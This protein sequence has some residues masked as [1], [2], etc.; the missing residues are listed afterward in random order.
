LPSRLTHETK[1]PL[2]VRGLRTV[3][4]H[5]AP[6]AR[7]VRINF[8]PTRFVEELLEKLEH[9]MLSGAS[10]DST[11]LRAPPRK[12]WQQVFPSTETT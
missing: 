12:H 1:Q 4:L 11:H 10:E 3:N 5:A 9:I 6:D 7:P 8:K 2:D